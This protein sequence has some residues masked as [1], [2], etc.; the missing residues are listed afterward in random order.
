MS[1][2]LRTAVRPRPPGAGT[3]LVREIDGHGGGASG[4]RQAT[5]GEIGAGARRD[6]AVSDDRTVN[7]R[8]SIRTANR[9]G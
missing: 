4:R 8:P 1:P 5:G 2:A 7:R 9:E 3:A 6:A